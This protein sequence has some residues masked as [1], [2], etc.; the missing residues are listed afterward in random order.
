[1]KSGENV[2]DHRASNGK[3]PTAVGVEPEPRHCQQMTTGGTG[4]HYWSLVVTCCHL[5]SLRGHYMVTTW[6]QHGQCMVTTC[7]RGRRLW[8]TRT[9]SPTCSPSRTPTH[10]I[11]SRSRSRSRSVKFRGQCVKVTVRC[12][13]PVYREIIV[14]PRT[15]EGQ[16]RHS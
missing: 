7:I 14:Y 16:I 9:H 6:S 3:S 10:V 13:G 15:F 8:R 5:W 11:V 4:G 1:M 12:D 2:P